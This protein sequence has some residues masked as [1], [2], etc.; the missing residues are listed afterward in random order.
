[1]LPRGHG[2]GEAGW[3]PHHPSEEFPRQ[4]ELEK[5]LLEKE[6]VFPQPFPCSV[7]LENLNC[8][9]II[10]GDKGE[11]RER[12]KKKKVKRNKEGKSKVET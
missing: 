3:K 5:H 10:E 11:G 12:G 4:G 6:Q 9:S 1:M 2:D 8:F 7:N